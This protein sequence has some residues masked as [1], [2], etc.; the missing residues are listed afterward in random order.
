MAEYE[1][2]V[3]RFLLCLTGG[4]S[5][6]AEELT[7]ETFFRAYL[8]LPRFREECSLKSWLFQIAKNT[9][10]TFWRRQRQ[11]AGREGV[12]SD[13]LPSNPAEE[14]AMRAERRE[15]LEAVRTTL[16]SFDPKHRDVLLYRLYAG[17]PYAQIA[18]L[19]DLS[20]SSCKVL[21]F[22]GKKKLIQQ[23]KEVYHDDL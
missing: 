8:S 19:M 21:F 3:R 22:R 4:Q 16:C 7:Q 15:M 17:L 5:S 20:E 6:L 18:R 11:E 9:C 14:P 13:S 23:L 2:D 1:E 10:F 12:L